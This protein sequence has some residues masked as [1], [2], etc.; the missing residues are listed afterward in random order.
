MAFFHQTSRPDLIDLPTQVI[1]WY[2]ETPWNR[3][4]D[5]KNCPVLYTLLSPEQT[6]VLDWAIS[7]LV[8]LSLV[9]VYLFR[10]D[11]RLHCPPDAI[12]ML[13]VQD[14]FLAIVVHAAQLRFDLGVGAAVVRFQAGGMHFVGC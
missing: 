7:P 2:L 1:L 10:T 13:F 4:V 9:V 6:K 14:E 3:S 5:Y 8:P 11:L 12:G